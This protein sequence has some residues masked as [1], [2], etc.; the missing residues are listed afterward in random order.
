MGH[1]KS[2][3]GQKCILPLLVAL[4]SPQTPIWGWTQPA[5]TFEN[6]GLALQAIRLTFTVST[7]FENA[8][9]D[10]DKTPVMLDLSGNDVARVLDA[11][12]AQRR[13]YV[14]RL[15]D[16]FYDVYPKMKGQSFSQLSV[17]NYAVKDATLREAVDAIDKLPKVQ[18]WLTHR[19]TR[20]GDLIGGSRLMPPRG[21]PLEPQSQR[22]Q[23]LALKNVQVRTILNQ[24]YSSFG[25]T[26]WVIWH[27]RQDFMMFFSL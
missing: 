25:E 13:T 2:P 21:A 23:S 8:I 1:S 22:R 6:I 24:I 11:L 12:V 20:R 15:N 4:L 17:A 27:E 10:L 26:H 7:G 16:G 18:R 19:H 5:Q 3:L 14:W 9:G